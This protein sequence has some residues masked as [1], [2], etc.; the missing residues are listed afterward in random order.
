MR[1]VSAEQSKENEEI[2]ESLV[3]A[4]LRLVVDFDKFEKENF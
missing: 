3:Y 1:I 2:E 4:M